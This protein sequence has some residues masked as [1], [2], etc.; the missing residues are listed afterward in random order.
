MFGISGTTA[1]FTQV[2]APMPG[3][4]APLIGGLEFLGG[5]ALVVGL[6][7]RLAALG[8]ALDMLGAIF[9][10]HL[11]AGFFA[12]N[13]VE[14]VLLLMVNAIALV[15]AGPGAGSL[16]GAIGRRRFVGHPSGRR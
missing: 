15:I 1:F 10:V 13:G 6:L 7:T 14:F 11:K 12:P 4:T 8:L 2:G 9:V 3:V 16:D 5:I